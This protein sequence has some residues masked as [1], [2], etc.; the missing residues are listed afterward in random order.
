VW[1]KVR[2]LYEMDS[3]PLW[4]IDVTTFI[5]LISK[6]KTV[7]MSTWSRLL[8]DEWKIPSYC[9]VHDRSFRLT[10]ILSAPVVLLLVCG[11]LA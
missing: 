1:S 7:K 3:I 4:L 5:T 9:I 11:M 2:V 8:L 10:W 6:G